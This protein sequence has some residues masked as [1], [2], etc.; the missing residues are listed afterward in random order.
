MPAS[1]VLSQFDALVKQKKKKEFVGLKF[2]H[3]RIAH[4]ET[5]WMSYE[6]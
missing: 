5:N 6:V 3:E 2:Y 1:V 4:L